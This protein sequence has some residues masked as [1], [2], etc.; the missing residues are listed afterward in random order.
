VH[1]YEEVAK[2]LKGVVKVAA[3][4]A[5]KYKTFV[6]IHGYPQVKLILDGRVIDFYG[7]RTV[8]N[9]KKF[10]TRELLK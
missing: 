1:T 6:K 7:P 9:I 4:D 3:I 5:Y 2:A 8:K 10:V